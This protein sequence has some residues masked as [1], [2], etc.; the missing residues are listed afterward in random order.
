LASGMAG[1]QKATKCDNRNLD[2][3]DPDVD[4]AIVG[5]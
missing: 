2:A 3:R 5:A 4:V 1:R